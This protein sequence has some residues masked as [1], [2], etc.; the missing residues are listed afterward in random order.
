MIDGECRN[1]NCLKGRG[2]NDVQ[3]KKR[4]QKLFRISIR[5]IENQP[6]EICR[7]L[8]EKASKDRFLG[9]EKLQNHTNE[10]KFS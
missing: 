5:I 10:N 9:P 4:K 7:H 3:L 2:G 6:N 1:K 8:S